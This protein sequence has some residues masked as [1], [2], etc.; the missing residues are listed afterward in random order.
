MKS[1][2]VLMLT[3]FALPAAAMSGRDFFLDVHGNYQVGSK[4][5]VSVYNYSSSGV[6]VA[7]STSISGSF[8]GAGL[9]LGFIESEQLGLRLSYDVAS[10]VKK[11][12]AVSET[13]PSASEI[14][15]TSSKVGMTSLALDLLYQIPA[16]GYYIYLGLGAA[17]LSGT[18]DIDN[19][20]QPAAPSGT[21]QPI[22]GTSSSTGYRGFVGMDVPLGQ[23]MHFDCEAGYKYQKFTKFKAS[24]KYTSCSGGGCSTPV[25]LNSGD[26]IGQYDPTTNS[27]SGPPVKADLSGAYVQIGLS[28]HF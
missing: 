22:K 3:L 12:G 13:A 24:D 6:T 9:S 10:T 16:S 23:I 25:T 7:D 18:L 19:T 27:F 20:P 28:A 21:S 2:V 26:T 15:A 11:S 5:D 4:S 17:S 1:T 8:P 14:W